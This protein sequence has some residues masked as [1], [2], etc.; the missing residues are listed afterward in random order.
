MST[1]ASELGSA[2]RSSNWRTPGVIILRSVV[3]V[4]LWHYPRR[5]RPAA[6]ACGMRRPV[7]GAATVTM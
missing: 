5:I 7:D 3:A 2:S 4:V 1:Q 6:Y